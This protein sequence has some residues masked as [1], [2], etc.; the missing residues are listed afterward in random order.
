MRVALTR[1]G[2]EPFI[3]FNAI[4]T[5]AIAPYLIDYGST[6][7]TSVLAVQSGAQVAI[8]VV[9]NPVVVDPYNVACFAPGTAVVVD[10][11]PL[12]ELATVLSLDVVGGVNL[13]MQLTL[14]HGAGG[15]SYPVVLAGGE[16]AVREILSRLTVIEG[17]LS[18]TAP[19]SAGVE[20]VD[21]IKMSA[22]IRGR[23]AQRNR[24]DD[25]MV[26]RDQARRD[27]GDILGLGEYYLRKGR[28][29]GSR[30]ELY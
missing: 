19:L 1:I 22:S 5:K 20:A 28:S 17:Q 8:A 18:S 26:Q 16:F 14:A 15:A 12:Q 25:L 13:T 27:L 21:E 4:F 23:G 6:S 11:G 9:A 2:A 3:A 7:A 29:G 10:V 24:F 30:V